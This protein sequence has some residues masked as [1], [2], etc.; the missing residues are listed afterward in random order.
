[1]ATADPTAVAQ[2][3]GNLV[4]NAIKFSPPG[5]TVFVSVNVIRM[6]LPSAWSVTKAPAYA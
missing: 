4:S 1:M 3:L 2:I 5:K 6:A